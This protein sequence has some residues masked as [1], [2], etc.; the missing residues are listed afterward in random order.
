MTEQELISIIVPVYKAE[1][2]L[3]AC[4]NSLI[5]QEYQNIEIILIVDGS[6]DNSL[7]ICREFAAKDARLQVIDQ[8][9]QGVSA[10]RNRGIE[11][12]RGR[13]ITFVDSDDYLAPDYLTV[14]YRDMV[15]QDVDVA[16]CDL[17]EVMNGKQVENQLIRIRRS[18]RIGTEEELFESLTLPEEPFW[19][20]V[21]LKLYKAE[22][23]K[24]CRFKPLRYGEDLVF[25]FD[26]CTTLKPRLYLNTYQ[27]YY[28]IRNEDSA[29]I[30]SGEYG[31]TKCWDEVKMDRYCYDNFPGS[32]QEIRGR[33]FMRYVYKM[34]RQVRITL[35]YGDK[36]VRKE[37]RPVLRKE[38]LSLLGTGER[39]PI[40]S[41]VY[42]HL[43]LLVPG[44]LRNM[45]RA[46][47][48]E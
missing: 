19:S 5:H 25:F 18:R 3:A 48:V 31:L 14:L 32:S 9:N 4:L 41:R 28:Y 6:P 12:A 35:L 46:Q 22:F 13:Y 40:K 10:A 23:V 33:F 29:T 21:T 8:E 38:I 43:Y 47:N 26:L 16:C 39:M 34:Q 37:Q 24:Q 42:F 17:I 1:K 2:Y 30:S 36:A 15:E 7:A 44:L 20:N 11:L 45:L 27:G